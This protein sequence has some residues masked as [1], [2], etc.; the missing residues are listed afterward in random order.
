MP[1]RAVVSMPGRIDATGW[2]PPQVGKVP[3]RSAPPLGLTKWLQQ[4][5]VP[6]AHLLRPLESPCGA[7]GP[8]L[9]VCGWQVALPDLAPSLMQHLPEAPLPSRFAQATTLR[10]LGHV[11]GRLCAERGVQAL[12]GQPWAVANADSG[13]PLWPT[14]CTGSISH[15]DHEACAVVALSGATAG[16]GIDVEN[17]VSAST[18]HE[19]AAVCCTPAERQR[20]LQGNNCSMPLTLTLTLIFAAKECLYKA[21]APTLGR[22]IDF[23]EVEVTAF[24]PTQQRLHLQ[25]RAGGPLQG[26]LV[27]ATAHYQL[28]AARTRVMCGLLLPSA[29]HTAR[30]SA[31]QQPCTRA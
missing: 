23:D 21:L 1:D 29:R 25:P 6:T 9:A 10:R 17:V 7:T 28:N 22:F 27:Q 8:G 4:R 15:S 30:P 19:L 5:G 31:L 3:G 12:L 20:W 26:V 16:L 13:A 24:V 18:A 11:A 14:G 2:A